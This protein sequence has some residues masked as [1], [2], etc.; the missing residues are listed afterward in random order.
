[1]R[2]RLASS[3]HQRLNSP[4][5]RPARP[6]CDEI[7]PRRIADEEALLHLGDNLAGD[8]PLGR[9]PVDAVGVEADDRLGDHGGWVELVRDRDPIM[10]AKASLREPATDF[11]P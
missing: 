7:L 8:F 5:S 3:F 11:A 9:D 1:M 6:T 4:L 10:A 2:C